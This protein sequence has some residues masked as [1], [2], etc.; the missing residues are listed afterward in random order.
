M[1]IRGDIIP[2]DGCADGV[3]E[4]P[5]RMPAENAGDFGDIEAKTMGLVRGRGIA[6]VF[7][8]AGPRLE[9]FF[10]KIL[11]AAFGFGPR[12]EVKSSVSGIT[13]TPLASDRAFKQTRSE[14]K[15]AAE[16]FENVLPWTRGVRVAHG[17]RLAALQ[18]TDAIW[19]DTVLGPIT[20]ADDIAGAG[21][22]DA[23]VGMIKKEGTTVS[24]GDNFRG[25]FRSAV[26]VVPT[27][28]VALAVM[29]AGFEVLIAL[30]RG[31][32]DGDAGMIAGAHAFKDVDGAHDVGGESFL[33]LLIGPAD[34]RLRSKME[35]DARA[36]SGKSGSDSFR[37]ADVG[38]RVVEP[39]GQSELAEERRIGIGLEGKAVHLGTEQEQPFA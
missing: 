6:L 34:E 1:A 20:A 17:D 32:D 39:F 19:N 12:T 33:W 23:F 2:V 15:V 5:A 29:P 27:K 28:G 14:F 25:G 21:R 37:I 35:D 9:H 38:N 36:S 3:V 24:G 10:D 4:I 13:R 18:M 26:A 31:Y 30:V 22:S 16:R 11:H 7:P 8:C